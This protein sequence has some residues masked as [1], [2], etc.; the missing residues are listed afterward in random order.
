MYS[1]RSCYVHVFKILQNTYCKKHIFG[2]VKYHQNKWQRD[3]FQLHLLNIKSSHQQMFSKISVLK[4]FC[5]FH[6]KITVL[7]SLF[8]KVAGLEDCNFIKKILQHRRFPV[9]LAK[10]LRT[11]FT[12]HLRWKH[13]YYFPLDIHFE[14]STFKQCVDLRLYLWVKIYNPTTLL[15]SKLLY[16]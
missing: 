7:E 11:F 1:A 16:R 9:K 14:M 6:S 3:L 4:I 5:K 8:N 13:L 10:F 15:K 2:K 12:K